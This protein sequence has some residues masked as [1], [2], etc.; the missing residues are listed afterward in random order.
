LPPKERD[1]CR[2]GGRQD[3]DWK[4]ATDRA[5]RFPGKHLT[6]QRV[7]AACA[8]APNCDRG[9]ANSIRVT[10]RLRCT[11][12]PL[13]RDHDE[14]RRQDFSILSHRAFAIIHTML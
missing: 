1:P 12:Q 3:F 14:A 7:F 11:D 4:S 2:G 5:G 6:W 13:H 10:N 8:V 9:I